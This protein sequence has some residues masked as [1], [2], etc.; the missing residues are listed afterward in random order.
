MKERQTIGGYPILGTVMQVDL[1]RLSQKKPGEHVRFLPVTIEQA[2]AQL[3]AF[4]QRFPAN[5]S[6]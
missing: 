3:S 4:Y 2:Q 5:L 6:S 1:F